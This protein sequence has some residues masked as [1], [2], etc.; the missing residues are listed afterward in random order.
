MKKFPRKKW[1]A[2]F[3]W[4]FLLEF[5]QKFHKIFPWKVLLE[6]IFKNFLRLLRESY[7]I[8]SQYKH[9]ISE[10]NIRLLRR[11]ACLLRVQRKR[12]QPAFVRCRG[13]AIPEMRWS[14]AATHILRRAAPGCRSAV[15]S[16]SLPRHSAGCLRLKDVHGHL[17]KYL[18]AAGHNAGRDD[19]RE[20]ET[21][22]IWA[23]HTQTARWYVA[24]GTIEEDR[25]R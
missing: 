8:D 22:D 25:G 12:R 21:R 5:S 9:E 19:E 24:I 4:N 2:K 10:T 15:P 23:K 16:G 17:K 20:S 7:H 1:I 3:P 18:V 13:G 11:W 14:R 6:V